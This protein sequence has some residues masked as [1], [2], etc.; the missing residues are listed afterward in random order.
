LDAIPNREAVTSGP[1]LHLGI[2]N[3]KVETRAERD[4]HF[5]IY[6]LDLDQD[7]D[8]AAQRR[9]QTIQ[10]KPKEKKKEK[11]PSTRSTR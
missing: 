7:M 11:N 5:E 3:N 10:T 1:E 4:L 6:S 2:W 8:S 9:D